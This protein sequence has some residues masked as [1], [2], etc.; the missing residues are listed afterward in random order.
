M[1]TN[2]RK[3]IDLYDFLVLRL[4]C[5][6]NALIG[7]YTDLGKTTHRWTRGL[8]ELCVRFG[9]KK[10]RLTRDVGVKGKEKQTI[11]EIYEIFESVSSENVIS[12]V[13]TG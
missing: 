3:S 6:V 13:R 5:G 8:G 1:T 2:G 7:R 10:S 9:P 11:G 12:C 4:G